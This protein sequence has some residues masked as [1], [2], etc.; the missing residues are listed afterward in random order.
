MFRTEAVEYTVRSGT[1]HRHA[2]AVYLQCSSVRFYN[3]ANEK[4][5]LGNNVDGKY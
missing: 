4:L 3:V 2:T 1:L 5:T